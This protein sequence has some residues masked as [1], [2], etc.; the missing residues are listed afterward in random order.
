MIIYGARHGQTNINAEH[1]A[2]GRRHGE[3]LNTI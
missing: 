1:I 2:Q 3:S